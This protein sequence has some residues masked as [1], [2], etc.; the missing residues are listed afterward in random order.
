MAEARAR[1]AHDLVDIAVAVGKDA[2]AH[3]KKRP[4][5]INWTVGKVEGPATRV[6]D[7][8]LGN[9]V[10]RIG[11]RAVT[12]ADG[13][14]D[15]AMNTGV[16]K[17]SSHTI[18][19]TYRWALEL[20][21]ASVEY[22]LPPDASD[23]TSP[24]AVAANE[25]AKSLVGLSRKV[26]KR[27]TQSIKKACSSVHK[28][29]LALRNMKLRIRL[30]PLL[31]LSEIKSTLKSLPAVMKKRSERY[32][33]AMDKLLLKYK[34]TAVLRNKVVG[35]YSRLALTVSPLASR[36]LGNAQ[37]Q[38]TRKVHTTVPVLKN[39]PSA[40]PREAS[41]SAPRVAVA[42]NTDDKPAVPAAPAPQAPD[43]E[44]A[45]REASEQSVATPRADS[46]SSKK[47]KVS[48]REEG[49]PLASTTQT[50]KKGGL[51]ARARK[52]AAGQGW[53]Q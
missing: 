10:L 37:P 12:V 45:A 14:I 7:S 42:A 27:A 30:M 3:A 23:A 22:V 52:A 16:Y 26:S 25:K 36:I 35:V 4:G 46:G 9:I 43:A 15:R 17:T 41:M 1:V 34:H 53:C 11:D 18:K 21:D 44:P 39:L 40:A 24:T 38:P 6:L 50:K 28:R 29:A 51:T 49:D 20:A 13:T 47:S 32:V 33:T 5:I 19:G 48:N 8:K 31:S 2:I